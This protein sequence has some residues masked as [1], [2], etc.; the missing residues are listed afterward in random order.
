MQISP[1]STSGNT[2]LQAMGMELRG[3][4]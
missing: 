2:N 4:V 1:R 3:V